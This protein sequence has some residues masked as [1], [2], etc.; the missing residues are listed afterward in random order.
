MRLLNNRIFHLSICALYIVL[1]TLGVLFSYIGWIHNI[2]N[3]FHVF[4]TN[5]SNIIA[6]VC[7]CALLISTIID[8]V[9][10]RKEGKETRF[11]NFSFCVFIYQGITMILYNFLT[12]DAHIFTAKFWSTLQCPVLH[13]FAPSL[14]IFMFI[15]FIDKEKISKW[16]PLFITI[17]PLIYAS[18][19]FIRSFIL[20]DVE[21]YKV[22]GY[23]KFPYPIFDYE[24]YP[25]WLI[26]IFMIAGLTVF[27]GLAFLMRY[28]FQRQ[29]KKPT[30]A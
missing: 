7:A 21:P 9:N 3:E 27:I 2:H 12:L 4:F 11:V 15:A 16:I 25:V 23:I 10:K 5:Q 18:F 24:T 17:Y 20:G 1:G 26:I 14:F 19:I 13:L 8:I 29:T 6:V 30:R 28:L 22:S